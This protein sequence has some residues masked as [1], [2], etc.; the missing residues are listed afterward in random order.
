MNIFFSYVLPVIFTFLFVW[1]LRACFLFGENNNRMPRFVVLMICLASLIPILGIIIAIGL[2]IVVF[3]C[4]YWAK[5]DYE[6]AG[7]R[8]NRFTRFWFVDEWQK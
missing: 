8:D 6:E 5:N 7:F 3:L 1:V 4:I 2:L